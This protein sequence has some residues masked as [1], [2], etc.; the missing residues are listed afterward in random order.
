MFRLGDQFAFGADDASGGRH[1]PIAHA[2]SDLAELAMGEAG[3]VEIA[4]HAADRMTGLIPRC[5]AFALECL[6]RQD[7][8]RQFFRSREEAIEAQAVVLVERAG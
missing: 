1:E 7:V 3:F 6:G 8:P 5:C 2:V 4:Q